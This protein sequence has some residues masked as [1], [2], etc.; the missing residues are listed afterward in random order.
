MATAAAAVGGVGYLLMHKSGLYSFGFFFE[1]LLMFSILER[2]EG[3]TPSGGSCFLRIAFNGDGV[4]LSFLG[5][6]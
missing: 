1:I 2:H 5:V 4:D 6:R 3:A